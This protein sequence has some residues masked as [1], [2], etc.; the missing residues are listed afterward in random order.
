MAGAAVIAVIALAGGG[1]YVYFFSGLRSS[2]S[3]L[4][5]SASPSGQASSVPSASATGSL[6]GSWA[7]TTGSLPGSRAKELVVGGT[8][9]NEAVARTSTLTP[10]PPVSA[11]SS[12]YH[13]NS[14]I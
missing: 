11:P 3:A 7:A 14:L 6:A 8:S 9:N 2:P 13:L 5:L 1:A 4:G 12:A 10:N